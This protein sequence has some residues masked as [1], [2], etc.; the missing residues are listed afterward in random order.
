MIK[1]IG[2]YL[3]LFCLFIS[4][5]YASKQ[6]KEKVVPTDSQ[7]ANYETVM[8]QDL[9]CLMMAY[10]EHITNVECKQNGNVYI[11]TQSGKRI[12]YDDKKK[13]S[14]HAKLKNPD[15]Q[16]MLEQIY[17]LS[18]IDRLMPENFD[19]GRMR[20]YTLLKE[21][22][23]GSKEQVQKNL[24]SVK[25]GYQTYSFNANNKA[26]ESLQK[27]MAELIPLTNRRTDIR[28][29]VFPC[30]GTFNY[31][32]IAGTNQLSAHSFGIAIDLASDKRDYWK[33]ATREDGEKRLKSYP[34][35]IVQIFE[36]NNF[37]WGG[38]WG[39]F[40]ILH[41]EYRPELIVK[42]KYFA[43]AT[44]SEKTW[45][46]TAPSDDADVA[47]YIWVIEKAFESKN[48]R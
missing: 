41:F 17:P 3:L 15:L 42:A 33:W 35:E 10:P 7:I 38:K 11:V 47:N 45:Y 19:P 13:K 2:I 27:V 24:A 14:Y 1:K 22:Y 6:Y 30:N 36:K 39:H 12:L 9:L 23:G 16:D 43:N 28:S 29:C 46:E 40:D 8:K 31:R 34:R 48:S 37:I 21:V 32:V 44:E 18:N 5:Q 20:V 4:T 25:I 26:A